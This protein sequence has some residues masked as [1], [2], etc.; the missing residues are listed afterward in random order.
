MANKAVKPVKAIKVSKTAKKAVVKAQKTSKAAVKV[1][2]VVAPKKVEKAPKATA[3]AEVKVARTGGTLVADVIGVDGK[4]AGT[5]SV[6]KDVFGVRVN[7]QLLAQ[8]IRVY[9]ANQREG[10]AQVKT[11]GNVEGSTR[12]IYR[13]KGTGKARHGSIRAP[14]FVGGGIV[15]GPETRDYTLKMPSQMKRK[16]LVSALTQQFKDGKIV[17]MDG[18]STLA[19][20]TKIIAQTLANA[21][22]VG[23]TLL[24]VAADEKNVMRAARNIAHVDVM[25]VAV[26][27]TYEV[28]THTRVV[29]MKSAVAALAA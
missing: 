27:N 5:M 6:P 8:A 7:K 1:A 19:P 9:L 25:P 11:R 12:K 21:G 26:V 29:L 20:K 16:A 4:K 10:A 3:K 2:K 15:F 24:V 14:I 13:Q 22:I 17:I 23:R 18:L 28:M